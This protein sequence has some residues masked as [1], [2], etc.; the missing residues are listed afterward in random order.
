M[1]KTLKNRICPNFDEIEK[2]LEV[3]NGYTN[4]KERISFSI[5]VHTNDKCD[6]DAPD[7]NC[8]ELNELLS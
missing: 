3:K 6:A 7:E 5:E 1:L 2:Y 4:K 8:K